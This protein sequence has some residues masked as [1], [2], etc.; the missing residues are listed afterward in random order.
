MKLKWAMSAMSAFLLLFLASM[1]SQGAGLS[2]SNLKILDLNLAPMLSPSNHAMPQ[3]PCQVCRA[4]Y[5]R[6][7][8]NGSAGN[9]IR[10]IQ[11]SSAW[12]TFGAVIQAL[13]KSPR[14][15]P[16]RI[17]GAPVRRSHWSF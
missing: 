8:T 1:T 5:R 7:E 12:T 6:S 13:Q 11:A 9:I 14:C 15:S 17:I 10:M 4:A 16:V 2:G 3:T